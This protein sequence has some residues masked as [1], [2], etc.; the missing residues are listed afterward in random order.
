MQTVFATPPLLAGLH[1]WHIWLYL[2][3]H[4]LHS[5]AMQTGHLR[6]LLTNLVPATVNM[7]A[8]WCPGINDGNKQASS[9]VDMV[10]SHSYLALQASCLRGYHV[11]V[12]LTIAKSLLAS[13]MYVLSIK[14]QHISLLCLSFLLDALQ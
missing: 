1:D 12:S 14:V 11:K 3:R 8:R 4:L 13:C 2:C 7:L 5:S 9:S 10:C 6:S